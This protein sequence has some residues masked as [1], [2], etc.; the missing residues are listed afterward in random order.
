MTRISLPRVSAVRRP[1]LSDWALDVAAAEHPDEIAEL[2]EAANEVIDAQE[3]A[4]EGR[5]GGDL[6]IRLKLLRVCTATAAA[7]A[8]GIAERFEQTGAGSSTTDITTRLTEVAG[9]R[10]A[11][12][13]LSRGL[14][15][16]EDPGVADPFGLAGPTVDRKPSAKKA[17]T[18]PSVEE[19]KRAGEAAATAKKELA[20]AESAAKAARNAVAKQETV[21][22]KAEAAS[23][24]PRRGSMP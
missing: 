9:N 8:S 4:M 5:D 15:G 19:R 20:A 18:G 1:G 22:A 11:L 3:A 23:P 12:D 7:L 10:N 6:R 14:L 21:L 13:L 16:A 24:R 2:V 17:P